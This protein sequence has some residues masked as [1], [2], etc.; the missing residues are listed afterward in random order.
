MSSS[1]GIDWTGT[2]RFHASAVY[3]DGSESLP[4]HT[5]NTTNSSTGATH[6]IDFTPGDEEEMDNSLQFRFAVK[7]FANGNYIFK[8]PDVVGYH[9]YYTH[10]EEN[11]DTFWSLGK[12][13]W[14]VG[15]TPANQVTT[16]DNVEQSSVIKF[17]KYDKNSSFNGT[18][19]L[20][21][22][23]HSY[24]SFASM[25]KLQT[26]ETLHGYS[27]FNMTLNARY[28]AHTIAGRRSFIG[29]LGIKSS[30]GSL[31]LEYHN[32]KMIISPVGRLDTFPYPYNEI[33]VDS[34]DGD[35]I[36][37]LDSMGDKV[38]QFKRNVLYII[39]IS[40]GMPSEFFLESKFRFRGIDNRAHKVRTSN[41]MFWVNK[42]GAFYYKD[43][44]IINL[45]L[46]GDD[47]DSKL[48]INKLKWRDFI[49]SNTIVG[50]EPS[51]EQCFVIKNHTHTERH[52]GDCYVYNIV[53]DNWTFGD[54]R[55]YSGGTASSV[56]NITNIINTGDNKQLSY[57]VNHS[58]EDSDGNI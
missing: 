17:T 13:I 14:N 45:T 10:S 27:P 4:L 34:S 29:N 50:Y 31:D 7:P 21:N 47:D 51:S 11:F 48:R 38:F 1:G 41:G 32:D 28:K 3:S 55:F 15:F 58:S 16:T 24:Y 5:F 39:N 33:T 6:E 36:I 8:G 19:M 43:G 57:I 2:A 40:S 56:R 49:T 44:D 9:F 37:A 25:P 23:T 12:V 52:H 20:T 53:L 26:Y 22:G 42:T 35:E 54:G 46:S 18:F 30:L